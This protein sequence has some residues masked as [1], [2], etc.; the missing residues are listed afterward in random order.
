[1][2]R[3]LKNFDPS[4]THESKETEETLKKMMANLEK[5]ELRYKKGDQDDTRFIYNSPEQFYKKYSETKRDVSKKQK[6]VRIDYLNLLQV[7]KRRNFS[8]QALP[9]QK[10]KL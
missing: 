4:K 10:L 2:D 8:N 7:K 1:L 9:N 3:L 6:D 5:E